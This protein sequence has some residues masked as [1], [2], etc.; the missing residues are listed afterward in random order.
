MGRRR[1]RD[2]TPTWVVAGAFLAG[3]SIGFR[4]QMAILT[5]PLLLWVVRRRGAGPRRRRSRPQ[6]RA[7]PRGRCRSSGSAAGRGG[8]WTR[9]AARRAKTSPASSCSGRT[10]RRAPPSPPSCRRSSVPGIRRSWLASCWSW[11]PRALLVLLV[12]SP[13]VLAHPRG[14][15]RAVRGLPPAL[16][17][18]AHHPL[19]PAARC[20]SS[21]ISPRGRSTEADA[22]AVGDRGRRARRCQPRLRR[23][24]PRAAYGQHPEPDL[25]AAL[26]NAHAAGSRRTAGRRH[27]PARVHRVQARAAVR[28]RR[29]GHGAA[30]LRATTSG[31]S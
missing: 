17:G 3:L 26:G 21:A 15:L 11:P 6:P 23:A 5:M 2:L 27:A 4:S 31:S 25:R 10:R 14:G 16:P 19:R 24:R 22:R 28:R 20:R 1:N 12:R 18:D 7:S 29:A 8:T 13:R 9:S 30:R